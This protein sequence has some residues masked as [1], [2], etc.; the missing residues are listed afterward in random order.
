MGRCTRP[1][2]SPRV[3][4]AVVVAPAVTTYPA[5]PSMSAA[6]HTACL[7][8]V[9]AAP[10]WR[11]RMHAGEKGFGNEHTRA[12][13]ALSSARAPTTH[14]PAC[15]VVRRQA[16]HMHMQWGGAQPPRMS[17]HQP[18]CN[19]RSAHPAQDAAGMQEALAN[20]NVTMR[21]MRDMPYR[22]ASSCKHKALHATAAPLHLHHQSVDRGV[23]SCPAPPPL[24]APLSTMNDD[25]PS[26]G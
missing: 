16:M 19:D 13:A 10:G 22:T 8:R 15:G 5:R 20:S 4:P 26:L 2:S 23:L 3:Q 9:P 18:A 11:G 24:E 1:A 14:S 6:A 7:C 12:R 25:H 17:R 21:D